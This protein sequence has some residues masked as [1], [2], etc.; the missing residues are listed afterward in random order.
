MLDK[1][2]RLL[3]EFKGGLGG[4]RYS[5]KR[6]RNCSKVGDLV[7][8]YFRNLSKV[9]VLLKEDVAGRR[10]GRSVRKKKVY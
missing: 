7:E 4:R 6:F 8:R 3:L 2:K 1:F 5:W 9:V 10:F